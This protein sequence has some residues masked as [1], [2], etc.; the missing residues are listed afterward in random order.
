VIAGRHPGVQHAAQGAGGPPLLLLHGFLGAPSAWDAVLAALPDHGPAWC[1]WLPGHGPAPAQ[2]ASWDPAVQALVDALPP[3]AV[4]AG[5]SMG[6]RLALAAAL[7]TGDG[8]RGALLV[9]GHVGLADERSR[10]ERAAQ[11]AVRAAALRSGALADFVAAWEAQPLFAT[12]T[13]LPA[14]LQAQQRAMRLAHDAPALAWSFEVAG[15]ACM[16]D[17]RPQLAAARRPL[18]FLTG[19]LD[20]RFTALADSLVRPPWITHH[21]VAGA[22]HNLLLEAPAAV[23]ASLAEL[24]MRMENP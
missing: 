18:C 12:Q 6:A 22:G 15:L 9:G 14:A 19:A 11:D 16:P 7:R 1:P 5:Y 2:P 13:A 21:T 3:G 4:L 8:V 23:A 10:A 20:R 24:M 17:L